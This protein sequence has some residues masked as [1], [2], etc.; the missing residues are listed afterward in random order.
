[1]RLIKLDFETINDDFVDFVIDEPITEFYS[2]SLI[3][4]VYFGSGDST[5][6]KGKCIKLQESWYKME[7]YKNDP[8]LPIHLSMFQ[9]KHFFKSGNEDWPDI[10]ALAAESKDTYI[11]YP[12][13]KNDEIYNKD[14]YKCT[15][16]ETHVDRNIILVFKNGLN[17]VPNDLVDLSKFSEYDSGIKKISN[18]NINEWIKLKHYE[19]NNWFNNIC[20]ND[21]NEIFTPEFEFMQI[22]SIVRIKNRH[23][24]YLEE[25]MKIVCHPLRIL[26]IDTFDENDVI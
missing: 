15:F 22:N 4:N 16:Y 7:F 21:K 8:L 14:S 25:L 10:Y 5:W 13:L 18:I 17:G 3:N 20:L 11:M 12:P 1:M 24:V 23:S 9:C 2:T 6:T 19:F 26:Q